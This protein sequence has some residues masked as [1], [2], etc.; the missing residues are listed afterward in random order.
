MNTTR[1]RGI[2][3]LLV[4]SILCT[5]GLYANG[6]NEKDNTDKVIK[7]RLAHIFQIEHPFALGADYFAKRLNE[8]SNGRI[9]VE[10]YPNEQLGNEKDLFD[11]VSVGAL[12]F[13]ITGYGE[14]GKRYSPALIVDAPYISTS[15]EQMMRVINSDIFAEIVEGVRKASGVRTI[16]SAYYGTRYLTTSKVQVNSP[17]D[18]K[19]LKIRT[20]GNPMLVSTIEALGGSPNPMAF[21][22]VYLA[23]QQGVVDGQENPPAAIATMKFFEVQKYIIDTGHAIQANMFHVSDKFYL[24]LPEDLQKA[25]IQA[26]K[27]TAEWTTQKSYELEDSYLKELISNGMTL[28]QPDKKLFEAKVQPLYKEYESTWGPGMLQR[29]KSVK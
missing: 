18:M 5:A 23:L 26:G 2:V 4:L 12:E 10:I 9:I 8:L 29:I 17:A 11:A 15:R 7:T 6:Q 1:T 20:P 22:E 13:A 16:A 27:E 25:I 14:A 19:G 21:S 24:T 28:I 3:I